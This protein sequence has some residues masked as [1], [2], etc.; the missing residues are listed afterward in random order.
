MR[1]DGP[2]AHSPTLSAASELPVIAGTR[3]PEGTVVGEYMLDRFLGAGAMGEVYGG[4]HPV[5][6]K[7]VAIKVLRRELASSEEAAERFT[8]E[9]RA[10]NQVDHP[11]V[12]DVFAYG[13]LDDGRLYLV[14]DL[15]AGESL[16]ARLVDGALEVT[17]ALAILDQIAD[18]LDAAHERGVVHRDLKPDNIMVAES[19]RVFVLDF[20]IAKL[21]TSE[22]KPGNGTLTGQGTWLGTP[23]YMAPEQWSTDG[24]GPASDRY[25][26]GVIAFELLSGDLPFAASSVPAMM[27]QHFRAKIPALSMRGST[28]PAVDGV[29]QRALA[30]DPE[31]R[32]A[33]GK[34]LVAAL[35]V[36]A[37][38][39]SGRAAIES[40][41]H[42]PRRWLFGA[43]GVGTLG[44]GIAGVMWTTDRNPPRAP[45]DPAI[46]VAAGSIAID[47]TSTP[48]Q[49]LV[50]LDGKVAGATPC[51]LH[52]APHAHV[53]LTVAKPGYLASHRRFDAGAADS[54]LAVNLGTVTRFEGVWKLPAG[55][56]RAFERYGDRVA[57]SKVSEVN[58]HR[59]LFKQYGFVAA[60]TGVAFAVDDEVVDPRAP[61][62]KSCHITTHVEYRYDAANDVL[63][64]YR[65]KVTIDFINGQCVPR[66]QAV[67][68]ERMIRVDA[69][70]DSV[71]ITAPAGGP[72]RPPSKLV[73]TRPVP[74]FP[75]PTSANTKKA[76]TTQ[77]SVVPF[78]T[79][80]AKDANG[81]KKKQDDAA[82]D[83]TYSKAQIVSKPQATPQP[84]D[85][86][87]PNQAVD[88]APNQADNRQAGLPTQAPPQQPRSKK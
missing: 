19:Q 8:R 48:D 61:D 31:A 78:D 77:R 51:K 6:G 76:A 34:E 17:D 25:A 60:D 10:V 21:F 63:E 35:R 9:A 75:T 38:T 67:A 47:V 59:E 33:T 7:K 18:A 49:A 32:F 14:M 1:S 22:S 20:G 87:A 23:A 41:D 68:A 5:I 71:E 88:Q 16:R 28:S 13:R 79:L 52:V 83:Q 2:L 84:V 86:Q 66:S 46:A 43:I 74:K 56:L 4:H 15:V 85:V 54:Q 29:M 26:L 39:A 40:N 65:P 73:K 82:A 69:A 50:T 81:A 3:L 27:E 58:G 30:K 64:L 80:G 57:V 44:L 45:T 11:N 42:K 24:A 70:H 12:I 55:E 37:G 72:Q 53:D 36:A 62:D